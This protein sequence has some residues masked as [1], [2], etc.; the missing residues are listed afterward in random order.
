MANDERPAALL[1]DLRVVDLTD[2][3]G[4]M[5]GRVLAE[6]GAEV[7]RIEHPDGGAGRG[8][9]PRAA[10]GTGLH[11]AHRNVGKLI[12]TLDPDLRR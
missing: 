10:D 1:D 7:V 9:T 4:A 3:Y 6:L 8:R 5:A 2:G 11:H 12:V